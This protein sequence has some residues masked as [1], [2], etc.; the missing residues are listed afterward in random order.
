MGR[1]L[2]LGLAVGGVAFG[3]T[4]S[5][6]LA[7][8]GFLPPETLGGTG[9]V[10]SAVQTAM[11]PNG[12]AIAG[13]VESLPGSK[14]A[15][16]VATRP[17]GGPWSS[18]QQLDVT[19]LHQ[20]I[21]PISVAVDAAG[22]AAVAW[23]DEQTGSPTVDTALVA[24]KPAAQSSFGAPQSLAGASDPVVGIDSSGR[25]TM[26]DNELDGPS[27]DEVD[28]NWPAGGVVPTVRSDLVATVCR[29]DVSPSVLAEAPSGDAIAGAQCGGDTFIRR[30]A[31][32][33]KPK[34][35]P[36]P[37]SS[38]GVCPTTPTANRGQQMAVAI[39][40][41]GAVAGAFVEDNFTGDCSPGGFLATDEY[42]LNLVLGAGSGVVV[43]MPPVDTVTSF[44]FTFGSSII[45]PEI[46]LAPGTELV[47]W[48]NGNFTTG[49]DEK[50][51]LFDSS[52]A[53]KAA[54]Q[55]LV[56]TRM[57]GVADIAMNA[58]GS[59]LAVFSTADG[60]GL[61]AATLAS[62]SSS[63]SA[64]VPL[65]PAQSSGPGVAIDDAGDGLATYATG[66]GASTVAL[67]RGFDATAP[68]IQSASIP[69]AAKVAQTVT[70][71]GTATDF[72]GPVTL[73]WSFGDG[74][75]GS[76][77]AVGH[78]FTTP[79]TRTVTVTATDAVGNTATRTGT[80]TVT[81]SPVVPV[82]SKV[83]E[84]HA[85]FRVG[86]A[87]T[88]IIAQG[89]ERVHRP[90][91]GTTFVFTL[92]EPAA[93]SIRITHGAPGRRSGH[94]CVKPTKKLKGH[95]RCTRQVVDG[96]LRRT[97]RAGINRVAFSGRIGKRALVPGSYRVTLTAT[98]FGLASR[99]RTMNFRIVR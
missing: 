25:V 49:A 59:A 54:A 36:T 57:V 56:T 53:P 19:S 61:Q 42:T 39:D 95:K 58:A 76:G 28:R 81:V 96:T 35:T 17:P 22:D 37:D 14:S 21:Y 9:T 7:A 27:H 46:G 52:G 50:V 90:P 40:S 78:T 77:A 89:R 55:T 13:W 69:A 86:R 16:R 26:I 20:T 2:A 31:G 24:T 6:A 29:P 87:P 84:T 80:V 33:W 94:S 38:S 63:F 3:V 11:A 64:P 85:T 30:I 23:D 43:V 5:S 51:R 67:A 83:S 45:A 4:C 97:G 66:T 47:A 88:P 60:S 74:G 48:R 34:T 72:W 62:G 12:F 71:S 91:I 8:S 82:L 32:A 41:A 92:S 15:I 99:P 93:V 1:R 10:Q 18:A 73:S 75:S 70:F 68:T 65:A 79:G 98:E 44:E